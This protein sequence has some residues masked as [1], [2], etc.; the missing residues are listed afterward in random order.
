VQEKFKADP[1]KMQQEVMRVYKEHNMS[2]FSAVS[3]CL[4]MLLPMPVFITL[5]YV[6]RNTIEFRGVPF[7]YLTDIS[8]RDPTFII[9]ILMAASA[10]L[11]SWIGMRGMPPNPQAKIMAYMFP[12]MMF[13]FFF[14]T[15]AGLNL[16]YMVQNIAALPQQWL[17]SNERK[18]TAVTPVVY[19]KGSPAR[20]KKT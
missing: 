16:Y 19:D 6:F 12:A 8:Q 18:K 2:P 10:F 4:P 17:I 7:L 11:L 1:Q 13:V 3:G 5:F 15:A 9:P 14:S 20:S